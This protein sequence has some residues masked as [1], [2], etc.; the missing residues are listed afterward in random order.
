MSTIDLVTSH[1]GSATLTLAVL[2]TFPIDREHRLRYAAAI[3][4]AAPK[5]VDSDEGRVWEQDIVRNARYW[6]LKAGTVMSSAFGRSAR[7]ELD[8]D[9]RQTSYLGSSETKLQSPPPAAHAN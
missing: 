8:L 5:I 9:S 2:P 6:T 3:H 7:L 4:D 1:S